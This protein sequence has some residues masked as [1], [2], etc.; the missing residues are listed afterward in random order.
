[1]SRRGDVIIEFHQVGAYVKVSAVDTSTYTEVSIVG[2][3]T[4]SEE[5]LKRAAIRKLEYVLER[6]RK[7]GGRRV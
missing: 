5:A 2:D 6:D 4:R 3:P 7:V 1:M